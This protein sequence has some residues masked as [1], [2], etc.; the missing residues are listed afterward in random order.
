[1]GTGSSLSVVIPVHNAEHVL[2]DQLDALSRQE[3]APP[4]DVIVV[5]NRCGDRSRAVAVAYAS[6]LSIRL[7]EANDRASAAYARNAGARTSSASILLFCDADD[8]VGSAWVAE[9]QGA[10]VGTTCDFVGGRIVVDRTSIPEWLYRHRYKYFDGVC[11]VPLGQGLAFPMGASFGCKR[12]AFDAVGGFDESLPGAGSEESE[13]AARLLRS[14]YRVG[15]APN[16]RFSYRPRTTMRGC[17]QQAHG[18]ARGAAAVEAKEGGLAPISRLGV[19]SQ[20]V[21]SLGFQIL[22][23]HQWRPRVLILRAW[24][25]YHYA[26]EERRLAATSGAARTERA[27]TE[28]LL[29]PV[30]TPIIGGLALVADR[31]HVGWYTRGGIEQ[32]SIALVDALLPAGGTFIDIGANIGV[33]TLAAALASGPDGSVIAFEPSPSICDLLR[34][35]V[36]RHRISDRVDVRQQAVSRERAMLEF[37][38]YDNDLISRLVTAPESMSPGEV[39]ERVTVEAVTLD[40]AVDGPVDMIKIDVEGLE[41]DVLHGARSLL[42]GSPDVVLIIEFNPDSLRARGKSPTELLDQLTLSPWSAWL[43]DEHWTTSAPGILRVDDSVRQLLDSAPAGWYSNLL[44][45]RSHRQAH[46]QCLVDALSS[47]GGDH[48]STQRGVPWIA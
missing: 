40:E 7:I 16:A 3:G 5:L 31:R 17:L 26:E 18:Y 39:V 41:P 4:F 14:G 35:N 32:R 29:V 1:M 30:S 13:M 48:R 21:K 10:L 6:K 37:K 33:F 45:A 27:D 22:R 28:D 23:N 20:V 44:V 43:I 42:E 11:L 25:R 36:A 46:L 47:A 15:E 9:M 8:R 38:R 24:V 19:A 2:G 34:R 12:H